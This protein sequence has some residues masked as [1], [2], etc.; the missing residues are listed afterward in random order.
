MSIYENY[1]KSPELNCKL[2]RILPCTQLR[3]FSH[4]NLFFL[5]CSR[6]VDSTI[7]RSQ[8]HRKLWKNSTSVI[9]KM[10]RK[11]WEFFFSR[12][13]SKNV[14]LIESY[15]KSWQY[16]SFERDGQYRRSFIT[17]CYS[18]IWLSHPMLKTKIRQWKTLTV[19]SKLDR[20]RTCYF[21][22]HMR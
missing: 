20:A 1:I 18:R 22:T 17:F 13:N 19:F 4:I 2:W 7:Q 5:L 11:P 3:W 15:V 8:P 10:M 21:P 16:F 12:N 14:F 6:K 9:S